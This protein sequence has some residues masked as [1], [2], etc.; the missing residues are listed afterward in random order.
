MKN[1]VQRFR[2]GLGVFVLVVVA[3][4]PTALFAAAGDLYSGGLS[5]PQA[6]TKFTPDGTP[7]IFANNIFA[8][9]L[10]FDAKGNLFVGNTQANTITKFAP[11]GAPT[12]FACSKTRSQHWP[13]TLA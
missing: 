10:A 13:S 8:D 12:T 2:L 3:F 9:P 7:T 1:R 5:S 11:N 6:I 4:S